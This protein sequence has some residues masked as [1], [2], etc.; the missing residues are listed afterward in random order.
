VNLKPSRLA[1]ARAERF[2]GSLSLLLPTSVARMARSTAVDS[3]ASTALVLG[4][5][6]CHVQLAQIGDEFGRIVG[7]VRGQRDALRT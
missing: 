2:F 4:Q 1:L 3:R 5:V 7:L 6:W